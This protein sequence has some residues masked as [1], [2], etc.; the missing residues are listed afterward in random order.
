MVDNPVVYS[1]SCEN[2]D[3][4]LAIPVVQIVLI[5][6]LF[7]CWIRPIAVIRFTGMSSENLITA[8]FEAIH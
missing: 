3:Y 4:R 2:F 1:I 8:L 7:L 6:V 5:L